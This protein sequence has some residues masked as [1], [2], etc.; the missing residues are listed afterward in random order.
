MQVGVA[1]MEGHVNYRFSKGVD[2]MYG[3]ASTVPMQ[4]PFGEM[5]RKAGVEKYRE[6]KKSRKFEKRI[7]YAYRKAY[8][9]KRPRVKG[10]FAKRQDLASS[11][12]QPAHQLP[13]SHLIN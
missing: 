11:H 8:A 3:N 1:Y 6:K 9:E 10:R 13:S 2:H 7:R 12:S 5:N 4:M